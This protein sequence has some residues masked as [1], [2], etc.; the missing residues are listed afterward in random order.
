MGRLSG[1][2]CFAF[3]FILLLVSPWAYGQAREF[4]RS[5]D[6][7][8][9]IFIPPGHFI[10]GIER[11]TLRKVYQYDGNQ[12]DL[13][14]SELGRKT[15]DLPGFFIDKY[16][17]TNEQ[18]EKFRRATGHRLPGY[19]NQR[20]Y[21]LPDQPVVGVGWADA[22]EYCR[23]AG[24]RLP[25]EAEWEK[26]ARGTD[27]RWWPWGHEFRTGLANSAEYGLGTSSPVGSFPAGASPYGVHDMAGNVWEI[28]DGE[29]GFR[30]DRCKVMRGGAFLSRAVFVRTTVRW[31]A[32]AENERNGAEWLGFRCVKEM[33]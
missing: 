12:V 26:A 14:E 10:M 32:K 29:W 2:V 18:Y 7:A 22:A 28:C 25:T 1:I 6:E 20:Q 4:H 15:V 13:F 24:K 11:Q 3:I 9:M 30:G 17:V 31:C 5:R 23:W 33:K 16:E 19:W 8:R 27:E 21:N